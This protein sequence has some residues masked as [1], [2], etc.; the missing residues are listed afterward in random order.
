MI[1]SQLSHYLRDQDRFIIIIKPNLVN[2]FVVREHRSD[3]AKE[4]SLLAEIRPIV[5]KQLTIFLF[6]YADFSWYYFLFERELILTS[7]VVC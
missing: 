5:S 3:N 6:Y 1:R 2:L 7:A 4:L